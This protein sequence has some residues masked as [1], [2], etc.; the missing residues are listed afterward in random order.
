MK[1]LVAVIVCLTIVVI[2]PVTG[3]RLDPLPI[4]QVASVDLSDPDQ[5]IA[6]ALTTMFTWRPTQDESPD[7]AYRRAAAYLAG[8]LAKQGEQ[9]TTPGPG[10]QWDQWR[11]DG[12]NVTAKVYFL[13]DETP[14]NSTDVTHRVV[15]VVQSIATLDNRL[16]DEIRHTAWVTAKRSNNGWRV[17]SIE[18]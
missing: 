16:I 5:V 8:D 17:T 10:S 11:S 15:V 7:T 6:D 13:A 3:C 1:K 9:T 4:D 14:P 12:A 2:G 18:F